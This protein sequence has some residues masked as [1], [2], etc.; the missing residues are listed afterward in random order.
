[1]VLV[2][3]SLPR[4]SFAEKPLSASQKEAA[5]KKFYEG[6]ELEGKGQW[7]EALK[8]FEEVAKF[9]TTPQVRFHIAL[10]E[11]HTGML[12]ES[13]RDFEAAE[14]DAVAEKVENVVNETPEHIAAV[15]QRLP[16][17]KIIFPDGA[18]KPAITIDG[19]PVEVKSFDEVPVNPGAHKLQATADRFKP[20][21]QDLKLDEAESKTI[22]LKMVSTASAEADA[23]G[24][25]DV[26]KPGA[27]DDTSK[28]DTGA[29]GGRNMTPGIIVASAGAAVLVGAGAFF[30]LRN[31]ARK[32]L[33]NSGLC[34]A[35]TCAPEAQS[36]IDR[37]RTYNAL[38]NVFAVVGIL[39]V[40][41]GVVLMVT[42]PKA[43][44]AKTQA[45]L[46]FVIGAPEANL[47][48]LALSGSF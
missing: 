7:G 20:F 33:D 37:G 43:E 2:S 23:G 45:S 34:T 11:E 47:G 26:E 16:K 14:R 19:A 21:S 18:E 12:V 41:T 9:R 32:D 6:R 3:A 5:T 15:K 31:S 8:R 4:L 35:L 46:R 10:C 25:V 38:T 24:S 42:A 17:L 1:M 27:G 13:M 39:G 22:T 44:P 36:T 48:G 30:L 29:P 28:P 40:G